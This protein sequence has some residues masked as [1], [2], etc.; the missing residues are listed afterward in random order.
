MN[1]D[2]PILGKTGYENDQRYQEILE[3]KSLQF[4]FLEFLDIFDRIGEHHKG[5]VDRKEKKCS[6]GFHDGK[7]FLFEVNVR[8]KC[9]GEPSTRMIAILIDELTDDETL[10]SRNEWSYVKLPRASIV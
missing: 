7:S 5:L 3:N 9:F 8:S 2:Q 4:F 6:K 10:K 1:L